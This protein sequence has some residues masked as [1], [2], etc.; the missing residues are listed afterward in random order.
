ML[1]QVFFLQS[2]GIVRNKI[3]EDVE[4]ETGSK[5]F[6]IFFFFRFSLLFGIPQGNR[7]CDPFEVS[8]RFDFISE[9]SKDRRNIFSRVHGRNNKLIYSKPIIIKSN[10]NNNNNHTIVNII[11]LLGSCDPSGLANNFLVVTAFLIYCVVRR[12]YIG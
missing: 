5:Y 11:L 1:I 3:L 2:N 8:T 4:Y 6:V 7:K 10:N 12:P 9:T